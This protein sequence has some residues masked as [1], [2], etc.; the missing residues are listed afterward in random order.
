VRELKKLEKR[1]RQQRRE[2]M[3]KLL[4]VLDARVK[5]RMRV[6]AEL[7]AELA[8]E[9]MSREGASTQTALRIFAGLA[10]ELAGLDS[11]NLH[12]Y[13]KRLKRVLYLAEISADCDPTAGE[14]AEASRKMHL[15]TG[16]WHDWQALASVAAH[17]LRECDEK[18]GMVP[19]LARLAEEALKRALGVCRKSTVRLTGNPG[20]I[21]LHLS[22]KAVDSAPGGGS[23]DENHSMK[24]AS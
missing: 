6:C 19:L 8:G 9:M 16:E 15:A 3:E 17:V 1:I 11:S 12:K 18:D 7:E 23:C 4:V 24:I 22:R 10:E 13:R 14:L 20:E 21:R 2:G 5:R